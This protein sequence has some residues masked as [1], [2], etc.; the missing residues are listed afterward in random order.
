MQE[1]IFCARYAR[2]QSSPV[3]MASRRA[4]LRRNHL[5]C[6]LQLS[7]NVRVYTE[8]SANPFSDH[9]EVRGWLVCLLVLREI[10][11]T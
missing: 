3:K 2:L 8:S 4:V 1:I 11:C 10:I 7:T 9:W 6:T 5:L